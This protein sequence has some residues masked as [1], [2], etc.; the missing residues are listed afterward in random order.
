MSSG[1]TIIPSTPAPASDTTPHATS[2]T[3]TNAD[4]ESGAAAADTATATAAELDTS[5]ETT[6][7]EENVTSESIS[8]RVVDTAS[9]V[10][11]EGVGVVHA[12]SDDPTSSTGQSAVKS[13]EP[14]LADLAF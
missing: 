10:A 13:G 11:Q 2:S 1:C 6:S 14:T 3:S 7:K 9:T 4:M 5:S 8:D 12:L